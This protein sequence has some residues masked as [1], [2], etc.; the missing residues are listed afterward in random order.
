MIGKNRVQNLAHSRRLGKVCHTVGPL[1]LGFF[2]IWLAAAGHEKQ[3]ELKIPDSELQDQLKTEADI[4]FLE[5]WF[6]RN[7]KEAEKIY[8]EYLEL[9]RAS[10]K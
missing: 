6:C 3:G 1:I 7:K 4:K 10:Q 5:W 8:E 2:A 9:L